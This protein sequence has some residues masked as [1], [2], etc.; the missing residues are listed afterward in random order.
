MIHLL[1]CLAQTAPATQPTVSGWEALLRSPFILVILMLVVFWWVM[2]RGR[3]KER[4]RY[5][6]MLRSLKKNDRVL[7]IGGIIGTVVDV[8][9]DEVVLKVDEA[10]NVKMRFLRTAIKGP[11]GE[12]APAEE[13]KS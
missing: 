5:E 12:A 10:A 1:I 3:S 8:R 6:Q 13:R 11:L 7:T 9:D 2:S 4:Q